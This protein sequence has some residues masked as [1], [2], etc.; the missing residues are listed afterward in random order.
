MKTNIVSQ[1]SLLKTSTKPLSTY[2]QFLLRLWKDT[3]TAGDKG[4][5]SNGQRTRLSK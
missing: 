5:D 4:G 1:P 2:I 3:V